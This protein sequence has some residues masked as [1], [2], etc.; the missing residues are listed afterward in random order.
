M[1]AAQWTELIMISPESNH[2]ICRG[3]LF[4][5][6]TLIDAALQIWNRKISCFFFT[7]FYV[8]IYASLWSA[9]VSWQNATEWETRCQEFFIPVHCMNRATAQEGNEVTVFWQIDRCNFQYTLLHNVATFFSLWLVCKASGPINKWP[10]AKHCR[11]IFTKLS[12][13]TF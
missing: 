3:Y 4:T 6:T 13:S 10:F 8:P 2:S 9:I 5:V 12:S 1:F 7:N 11:R